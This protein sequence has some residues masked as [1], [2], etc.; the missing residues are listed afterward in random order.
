MLQEIKCPYC[1]H[2]MLIST[3]DG[4]KSYFKCMDCNRKMRINIYHELTTEQLYG[5]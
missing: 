1:S 2:I 5:E 4:D 3:P